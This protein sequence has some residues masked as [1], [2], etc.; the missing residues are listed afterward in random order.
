MIKYYE[1]VLSITELNYINGLLNSCKWGFG[2][3]STDKNKP[4]WNFDKQF[5]KPIAEIIHSKL[6]D[7][8]LSD[9]HINGQTINLDAAPHRDDYPKSNGK[10]GCTHAFVYFPMDW[11][12]SWG[13]N[14]CIL[15]DEE[16]EITPRKNFG[17]LF[18]ANYMHYAKAPL[19][20][21]FRISVGLKLYK[22]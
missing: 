1:N 22:D 3:V 15:N 5:G 10:N 13:G 9:W 11:E 7:F 16:I 14:L 20:S 8:I 18:D 4:I 6:N 21:K 19:I 17:V 2:F 12:Q